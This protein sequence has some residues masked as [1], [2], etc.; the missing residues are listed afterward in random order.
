M[1]PCDTRTF[2]T[3]R[4]THPP[5]QNQRQLSRQNRSGLDHEKEV[6]YAQ[7]LKPAYTWKLVPL[8]M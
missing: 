1:T 7:E 8:H 2:D 5:S 3:F 6:K 4:D